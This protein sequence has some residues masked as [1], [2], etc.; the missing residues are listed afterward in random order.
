MILRSEYEHVQ[1]WIYASVLNHFEEVAT[2][3]MPMLVE[4]TTREIVEKIERGST[5]SKAT[6]HSQFFE[7][8]M[9]GPLQWEHTRNE[10]S[11]SIDVNVLITS[12]IIRKNIYEHRQQVGKIAAKFLNAIPVFRYDDTGRVGD[13]PEF[14]LVLYTK[15]RARRR[16]E[17]HN[18][19]QIHQ[20]IPLEQSTV[21]GNF[22]GSFKTKED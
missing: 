15:E 6:E 13:S 7:C 22:R 3:D 20:H 14:C 5:T 12:L 10:F 17:T 9:Y 18:F 21:E 19:G 8:R 2:S 11:L 4:G 16:L 1:R